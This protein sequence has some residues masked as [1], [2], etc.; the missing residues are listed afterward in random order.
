M[1]ARPTLAYSRPEFEADSDRRLADSLSKM[2]G[3]LRME[4][5][6]DG[7]RAGADEVRLVLGEL[8]GRTDS[9]AGLHRLLADRPTDGTIDLGDYLRDIAGAIVSALCSAGSVELSFNCEAHCLVPAQKAI[10][11]GLI[12]VELVTNAVKYAHPSGV[13]GKLGV[14]CRWTSE[15]TVL[16]SVS[17]DGVGLPEGFDPAKDGHLGF[18]VVRL[19]AA[20]LAAQMKFVNSVLGLSVEFQM[21]LKI[22]A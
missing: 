2:A 6:R 19:L 13:R 5:W 16:V 12:V 7:T 4:G 1:V 14:A 11:L 17:D 21:P 22:S 8:R 18:H 9:V 20:R 3:L 10:P 15:G